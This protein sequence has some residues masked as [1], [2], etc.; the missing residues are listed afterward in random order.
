[1]YRYDGFCLL[2]NLQNVCTALPV[3]KFRH[4][5]GS[6]CTIPKVNVPAHVYKVLSN[7]ITIGT[8]GFAQDNLSGG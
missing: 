1:M 8:Q 3:C 2:F 7:L 5:S 6:S 4:L